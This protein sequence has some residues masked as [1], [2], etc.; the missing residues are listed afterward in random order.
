MWQQIH[1]L[2]RV[3]QTSQNMF[4]KH[5][6][7]IIYTTMFQRT[8]DNNSL[9][10]SSLFSFSILIP[11]SDKEKKL[12][13]NNTCSVYFVYFTCGSHREVHKREKEREREIEYPFSANIKCCEWN[14]DV[15]KVRI[16][17]YSYIVH[18]LHT[19]TRCNI[20]R[21]CHSQF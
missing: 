1:S 16:V 7:P 9:S 19:H 18:G 3:T 14:C 5:Q 4:P 10:F 2:A 17:V 15:H 21:E 6:N 8:N 12:N 20:S 13:L 11:F